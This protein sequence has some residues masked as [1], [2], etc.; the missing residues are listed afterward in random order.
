MSGDFRWRH[1]DKTFFAM[2]RLIS[3]LNELHDEGWRVHDEHGFRLSDGETDLELWQGDE[4]EGWYFDEED[5]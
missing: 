3:S 5:A 2:E 1:G 4:D